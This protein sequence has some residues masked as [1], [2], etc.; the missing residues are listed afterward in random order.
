[1]GSAKT[2]DVEIRW[3]NGVWEKFANIES[4]RLVTIKEGIGIVPNA[5]WG[6]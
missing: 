2:A 6:K 3:P 1:L 5:G 4:D